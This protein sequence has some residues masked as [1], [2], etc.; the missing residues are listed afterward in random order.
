M[1]KLV[2][3][4]DSGSS[5]SNPVEVRVLLSAPEKTIIYFFD[6]QVIFYGD[7]SVS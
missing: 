1:V 7:S 3:T 5:G 4:L 6:L 2:D